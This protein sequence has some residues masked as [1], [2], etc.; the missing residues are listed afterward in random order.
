MALQAM[1]L[2]HGTAMSMPS[3]WQRHINVLQ[4]PKLCHCTAVALPWQCNVSDVAQ[5]HGKAMAVSWQ[6]Q[7]SAI[8][9]SWHCWGIVLA[10]R[11]L[12][13]RYREDGGMSQYLCLVAGGWGSAGVVRL[14]SAWLQHEAWIPEACKGTESDLQRQSSSSQAHLKCSLGAPKVIPNIPIWTTGAKSEP[15]VRPGAHHSEAR[16]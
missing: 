14:M 8:P 2:R 3:H 16:R 11:V 13:L 4:Q 1:L 5:Q 12:T 9:M 15:T 7:N 10:C 6:C